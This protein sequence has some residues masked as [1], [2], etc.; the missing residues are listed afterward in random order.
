MTIEITLLQALSNKNNLD[1]YKYLINDKSLSNQ[2]IVIIKDY[3][4]Y[5]ELNKAVEEI[6]FTDFIT[7]FFITRHP[8][9]DENSK[10]EY[11]EIFKLLTETTR[12]DNIQQLVNSFEQQEFYQQ[13]K[14]ELDNNL[15]VTRISEK[16][17]QFSKKV[18]IAENEQDMNLEDA[19]NQ[20]DR[21]N[22]LIW[23]NQKLK[24]HFN[25]G[26]IRGDFGIVAGYTDAGK[27]SFLASELSYIA[28][29]LKD[30]QRILWFNNEGD[31]RTLLPRVYSATLNLSQAEL[32]KY[33]AQAIK[34]Y[35]EVMHGDI[36]RIQI[37][38]IQGK[39]I[40]DIE[41]IIKE[42]QPALVI[43]DMLDHLRGFEKYVSTEGSHERFGKLYQWARELSSQYC[44]IIATSQ[45]NREGYN[46][47][48]PDI[49]NMK[50]SGVDKQAAAVFVLMIGALAGE[51]D[52]RYLS[53]PK[54]KLGKN[55]HWKAIVK[56]DSL[57][58]RF[59]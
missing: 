21:T 20:V 54:F 23:R 5:F 48:Y 22:G 8:Y 30:S 18:I 25:G 50:G 26:L 34:K 13:L 56:F 31:W 6:D 43:F 59:I 53:T 46:A 19:L 57:R 33:K 41:R 42:Q 1:K 28:Q 29:Q 52:V 55:A 37:L 3:E 11:R 24:E 49:I 47:M 2:S 14:R 17:E 40:K 36:N 32:I 27:T 51:D 39:H 45:L 10:L 7:F 58:S 15:D 38:D 35:K 12:S 16:I 44:P 4:V 9:L